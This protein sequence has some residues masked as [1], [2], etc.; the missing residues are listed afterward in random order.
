MRR[1]LSLLLLLTVAATGEGEG[2]SAPAQGGDAEP[3]IPSAATE[4][5]LG[6]DRL[7]RIPRTSVDTPEL[8][9]GKD[10]ATWEAEFTEAREEL[11]TLERR[12][13]ATQ[14]EL[15]EAAPDD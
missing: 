7:L 12:I 1:V 9:G 8:R 13:E 10:R 5:E 15:R 6:L 2:T 11:H 4:P 3:K 14:T